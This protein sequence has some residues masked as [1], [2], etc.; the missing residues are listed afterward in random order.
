M[1]PEKVIMRK[2][3]GRATAYDILRGR[4]SVEEKTGNDQADLLAEKGALAR[5]PPQQLLALLSS[6]RKQIEA[7]QKM[8]LQIAKDRENAPELKVAMERFQQDTR[9]ARR[10]RAARRGAN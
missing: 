9:F 7:F 6:Y 8:M 4:S 2:T 3:K 1:C 5:A 10:Q